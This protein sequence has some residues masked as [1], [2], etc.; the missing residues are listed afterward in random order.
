[1]SISV[2]HIRRRQKTRRVCLS[3]L[4]TGFTF[5]FLIDFLWAE[6]LDKHVYPYILELLE[7][8]S[9]NGHI[10]TESD[11]RKAMRRSASN[12]PGTHIRETRTL[13]RELEGDEHDD[14]DH[15][16]VS[17]MNTPNAS[18][19]LDRNHTLSSRQSSRRASRSY[20]EA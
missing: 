5:L 13:V 4:L 1:M 3:L 17:A 6:G 16:V 20:L 14:D 2:S 11:K 8:H 18:P 10:S 19:L 12:G 7:S 9:F 15:E